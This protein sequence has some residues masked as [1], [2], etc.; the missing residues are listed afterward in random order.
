[1]R[2]EPDRMWTCG[3]GISGTGASQR[4][5]V[6]PRGLS[7][8]PAARAAG[9]GPLGKRGTP[10]ED[11]RGGQSGVSLEWQP[12]QDGVTEDLQSVLQNSEVI[13]LTGDS[14]SE[15]IDTDE[16]EELVRHW[17][18][19]RSSRQGQSEAPCPRRLPVPDPEELKSGET[20]Q[21]KTPDLDARVHNSQLSGSQEK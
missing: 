5:F 10:G 9:C 18:K 16:A 15:D 11:S 14:E 6:P 1:M 3:R 21:E 12:D 7:Y 13:D 20:Q 4:P 8:G 19:A 17:L 2:T